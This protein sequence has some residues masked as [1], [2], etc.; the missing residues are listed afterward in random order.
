MRDKSI[1]K[2][3]KNRDSTISKINNDVDFSE[4]KQLYDRIKDR[5]N[6]TAAELISRLEREEIIIPCSIFDDKLTILQ[7][8]CKYLRE[9]LDLSYQKIASLLDRNSRIVWRAYKSS[10]QIMHGQFVISD[11]SLS[12]PVSIFSNRKMSVFEN[13]VV[14]LKEK[15]DLRYKDIALLLKRDE[16]TIWTVYKRAMV[17][18]N[19]K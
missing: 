14:Y 1:V 12:V 6:L 4:F 13:L 8:L 2:P 19:E 7:A 9:N 11:Y 16:R 15:R 17:K 3:E 10:I 5:Y 18:R